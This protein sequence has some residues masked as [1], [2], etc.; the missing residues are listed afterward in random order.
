VQGYAKVGSLA[1]QY[2]VRTINGQEEELD[3]DAGAICRIGRTDQNSIMLADDLV[4]R[5]HALIQGTDNNR[6]Y[7]MDLGSR[8]GTF[9]N[10]RRV[11]VP[12]ALADGDIIAIGNQEICFFQEGGGESTEAAPEKI[13][14]DETRLQVSKQLITVLVVDIRGYTR[15]AQ[16]MDEGT[17]AQTIGT[18][19][20]ESGVIL[21]Q[22][23]AW[24][25]KYIGDAVMGLWLHHGAMLSGPVVRSVIE[26]LCGLSDV[27]DRLQSQFDLDE[28]IRLGAGINSGFASVGNVGSGLIADHT[29]LGDAVNKAFR[30]ESSTRAIDCDL[31]LGEETYDLLAATGDLGDLVQSHSANLK[32]YDEPVRVFGAHKADFP[33][34]LD[35]A[36]R[37]PRTPTA[38][39]G[40]SR[41]RR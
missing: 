20:R 13:N 35:I 22:H 2:L 24:A 25:Q 8:N 9:L 1:Q 23:R 7:L 17:L 39:A 37:L 30:L 41:R 5:T 21:Q 15:L 31:A 28:P 16:R 18:F 12:A 34:L 38:R 40:D 11:T 14:F 29:A 19:V 27:A 10:R 6:F 26:A 33:A 3:L 32:G 4:S 36:R